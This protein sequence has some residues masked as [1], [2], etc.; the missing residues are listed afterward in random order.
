M[1]FLPT[2]RWGHRSAGRQ[3]DRFFL[4]RII[5]RRRR[6]P[7]CHY[8]G[9]AETIGGISGDLP[10]HGPPSRAKQSAQ[11]TIAIFTPTYKSGDRK[12]RS[13]SLSLSL[14]LSPRAEVER[15]VLLGDRASEGGSERKREMEGRGGLEHRRC[16]RARK[17][18]GD[19]K[20][21]REGGREE[22]QQK[23]PFQKMSPG[24]PSLQTAKTAELRRELTEGEGQTDR[25]G[26]KSAPKYPTTFL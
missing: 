18:G 5:S 3:S 14:P 15:A 4:S 19:N 9:Q 25:R 6:R 2:E 10:G 17:G 12:R 13:F 21:G 7:T 22:G 8:P 11:W 1:L 23:V 24:D 16:G 26:K 20:E